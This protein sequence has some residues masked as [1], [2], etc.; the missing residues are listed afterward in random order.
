ME[1][2]SLHKIFNNISFVDDIIT[3]NSTM[4]IKFIKTHINISLLE[5]CSKLND[6]S[7]NFISD[8]LYILWQQIMTQP[9]VYVAKL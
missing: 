9:H 5:F 7:I 2:V 4:I 3:I 6:L 1:K 8:Y